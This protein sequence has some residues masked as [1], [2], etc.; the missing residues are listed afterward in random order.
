MMPEGM[1]LEKQRILIPNY[2]QAIA[3]KNLDKTK[4]KSGLIV[5]PC[6]CGKTW[7][8]AMWFK[9]ILEKNPKARLLFMCH[10]TDILVQ[11]N[12]K[13][14]QR[15]L[16][17]FGI[18]YG[19]LVGRMMTYVCGQK[20]DDME[21]K[22][23]TFATVQTLHN[24][25]KEIGKD[26]FDYIIVDEAHH[27]QAP[28]FRKVVK[29]FKP[30]FLLGLTATPRRLDGL[31][32]TELF[33]KILYEGTFRDAIQQ[34]LL[35]KINYFCVDHDIDFSN[36]TWHG[37]AYDITELNKKVCVPEYDEAIFKEWKEQKT[38]HNRKKTIMFC[39]TVKHAK[40]MEALFSSRGILTKVITYETL[41]KHKRGERN[42][43]L[44]DFREGRYEV[45][46]VR[47]MFNEGIDVPDADMV[48]MLRPTKSHTIFTQ[49]LG[50]GMRKAEGKEYL[51][52]LDFTGN[53]RGCHIVTDVLDTMLG[54]NIADEIVK[55][56]SGSEK[57]SHNELIIR[58]L[59]CEVRLS[60]TR[61]D[62]LSGIIS[63]RLNEEKYKSAFLSLVKK[64][65]R[66]PTRTECRLN[67]FNDAVVSRSLGF[68]GNYNVVVRHFGFEPRHECRNRYRHPFSKMTKEELI[69]KFRE[70]VRKFGDTPTHMRFDGTQKVEGWDASHIPCTATINRMFNGWDKFC[71]AGGRVSINQRNGRRCKVIIDKDGNNN[72]GNIKVVAHYHPLNHILPI[73]KTAI[74]HPSNA[75]TNGFG[76]LNLKKGFK[77]S[78]NKSDI[79]TKILENIKDGDTVL[80]LESPQLQALKEI[81]RLGRKP[82]E[83]IIPNHIEFNAVYEALKDFK[84]DLN[85][86][87]IKAS[88]LQY[89]V[90]T[91]IKFNFMWL[92]YCGAFCYYQR[93]LEI[94]L[95]KQSQDMQLIL[96]YNLFDLQNKD[97]AYY[98]AKVFTFVEDVAT[99]N[100]RKVKL[101]KEVCRH[102]K[103]MFYNIGFQISNKDISSN[104][105]N[106]QQGLMK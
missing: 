44:R 77:D 68:N 81:Q 89:L 73:A 33:G 17:S 88:A 7:M 105:V 97:D 2:M 15:C 64:F 53:G 5:I 20:Y 1:K 92:D 99:V 12:E 30:K 63:V 76:R 93:D 83:I 14:F 32:L 56:K 9:K 61:L 25:L 26:D 34:N 46:I 8:A 82:K 69:A 29:H 27:Y 52:V 16:Q 42:Q 60:K 67:G 37:R 90:D 19:Y 85:I 3:L 21:K 94:I 45:A 38:L 70:F 96:T 62:V 43:A 101:M 95:Q 75:K 72:I 71:K 84:T 91:D 4:E 11:A 48:M 103:K 22:Q 100:G 41:K 59:G 10:N 18:T 39:P 58:N 79:R 47:D 55:S 6:G 35:T 31:P 78:L 13:E 87:L 66:V 106:V 36:I 86:T 102:Y 104:A 23:V 28:T 74:P 49:Q 24:R 50:R 98:F 80:L 40:R 65:G 57:R 51:L 54:M